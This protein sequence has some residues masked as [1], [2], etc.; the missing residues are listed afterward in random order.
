MRVLVASVAAVL[1]VALVGPVGAQA[2]VPTLEDFETPG[3]PDGTVI[4]NQFKSNGVYFTESP[5]N[6]IYLPE[7]DVD[8][9]KA[10]SASRMLDITTT[11]ISSP[12]EFP[13]PGVEGRF[14]TVV[15]DITVWVRNLYTGS[16]ANLTLTAYREGGGTVTD[17][18]TSVAAAEGW[19]E[20]K[21]DAGV[22]N[23]FFRFEI[24]GASGD[25]AK[26]IRVDDLEFTVDEAA[27]PSYTISTEE[28]GG[29]VLPGQPKN[30]KIQIQR[31]NGF[32]EAINFSGFVFGTSATVGFSPN[33]STGTGSSTTLTMTVAASATD[34]KRVLRVTSSTASLPNR[35]LDIEFLVESPFRIDPVDPLPVQADRCT[36]T[37]AAFRVVRNRFFSAPINVSVAAQSGSIPSD[38]GA[39]A[40]PATIL[41]LETVNPVTLKVT[42]G[43]DPDAPAS[44]PLKIVASSGG[45]TRSLPFEVFRRAPR[46]TSVAPTNL[47]APRALT[48]GT[49]ITVR[50]NGLCPGA[51]VQ[52]GNDHALAPGTLEASPVAGDPTRVEMTASTPRLA[53]DGQVQ[54]VNPSGTV[55]SGAGLPDATVNSYRNRYG[56]S[57][58]NED[59]ERSKNKEGEFT[60]PPPVGAGSLRDWQELVGPRQT[61]HNACELGL[62]LPGCWDI[63]TPVPTPQHLIMQ[64]I[65]G[66]AAF[67]NRDGTC[68][69]LSIA[70]RRIATGQTRV[71]GRPP[72]GAFAPVWSLQR[73]GVETIPGR[74]DIPLEGRANYSPIKYAAIQ[75]PAQTTAQYIELWAKRRTINATTG[76]GIMRSALERDLRAGRRP[77]LNLNW[78]GGGH[79]VNVY[80]IEDRPAGGYFIRVYDNNIPYRTSEAGN[81]EDH[82]NRETAWSRVAVSPG[83]GWTYPGLTVV[84]RRDAEG[85]PTETAP[86][87]GPTGDLSWVTVENE[88]PVVPSS[89]ATL[90]GWRA[91]ATP[92]LGSSISTP[93]DPTAEAKAGVEELGYL[94]GEGALV[95]ADSD[96]AHNLSVTPNGKGKVQV[97]VFGEGATAEVSASGASSA[98]SSAKGGGNQVML[99]K[100]STDGVGYKAGS[101]SQKVDLTVV[102]DEAGRL[103]RVRGMRG[104]TSQLKIVGKKGKVGLTHTGR[105]GVVKLEL[106]SYGRHG[107]PARFATAL[108]L[109]KGAKVTLVPN[110]KRLGGRLIARVNGRRLAL[111]NRAGSPVRVKRVR[112]S[113]KTRGKRVI[114]KVR[115]RLAGKLRKLGA[116][117][118][119]VEI[120]KGKKVVGRGS[121]QL[122]PNRKS[123]ARLGKGVKVATKLKKKPKGKLSARVVVSA[124][125]AKP[126]PSGSSKLASGRVR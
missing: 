17:F 14:T 30:Y 15:E 41:S 91:L 68:V 37:P 74:G 48:G 59:G 18:D 111:R 71:D 2:V 122:K 81:G 98:K 72:G 107:T 25:A 5:G 33:P 19:V 104:G 34:G 100:G 7:I 85:N 73:T 58:R 96:S 60:E 70:S 26:E 116:L 124:V 20:L 110:W 46:L 47:F 89:L 109:R 36:T 103:V 117:F 78:D 6:G 106:A 55:A 50:G 31:L 80:D 64:E 90:D 42:R 29:V 126:L 87:T 11:D 114:A 61:N 10:R 39:T 77:L 67:Y 3:E 44:I 125:V 51:Q 102:S 23:S 123:V 12:E 56:F 45:V 84:T 94:D 118:V 119:L 113:A 105:G 16:S 69:G 121:K 1:G 53:T 8:A 21:V 52:F 28:L 27:A 4:A 54:V 13:H 93:G 97:G 101:G 120:R 40:A 92:G 115:A 49:G 9:T 75:H 112:L 32:S 57:F 108:R 24:N 22:G 82:E 88:L 35:I 43:D 62:F 79:A 65:L 38:I 66:L 76:P 63:I 95:A 83:G 99:P 86:R